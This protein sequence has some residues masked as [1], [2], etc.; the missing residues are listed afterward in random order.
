MYTT[1]E[2]VLNVML[3]QWTVCNEEGIKT[4]HV[5][6]SSKLYK[7]EKRRQKRLT[8]MYYTVLNTL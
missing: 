6:F 3:F 8:K 4:V 5:Y 7:Q 2:L 1:N